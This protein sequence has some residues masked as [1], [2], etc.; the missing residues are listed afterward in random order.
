MNLIQ[1]LEQEE[2]A[3]LGKTIPDVRPRRH[4][5]RQRQR[6]R[7]HP[8]ARAGLRRRRDRQ[9]Q[10][11]PELELHRAQDLQ[12]RRRRAHVPDLQPADRLDRSQ[13]PR[14]R[15][16]RQAVLPAR[17][18]GQVGAHQGKAGLTR[19]RRR[20]SRAGLPSA[21]ADAAPGGFSLGL[22]S[23]VSRCPPW[24]SSFD[25]RSLPVIG[26]DDAPAAVPRRR[27]TPRRCARAS[28]RRR[29][30]QPEIS[31]RA[32]LHRPRAGAR[33]RCWCRIVLRERAD[34]AADPAHRPP[35]PT[36]RARSAFPAA[37][38]SPTTPTPP[39]PRCARRRRRSASTRDCVEVI[40][41]LPT[42]TTGTG[43]IV[44][45][46][47]ALVRPGFALHARSVRGGR[48][49]R[50][51]AGLPDGPGQPPAPRGR[52]RRRA[53][54]SSSRCP[55]RRRR[56]RRAAPLLHLGRDGGDAAQLY[57]FLAA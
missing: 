56:R 29:P 13:A 19:S 39:P 50:G 34:G 18:L 10:P 45:P 8:Q 40:G 28:P 53:R 17:A 46:V 7:R 33:R 2:I 43:F 41:A 36:T 30:G 57:R 21:A 55:G 47:V 20:R 37:A 14:R 31:D 38:P 1:T 16:P 3:R 52:G 15:A 32:P 27:L 44:T 54:A 9:A 26:V 42:Y 51:A 48:G 11:R 49:V 35:A 23:P 5:D 22:R 6:R 24:P 25:P 12:R 4:G